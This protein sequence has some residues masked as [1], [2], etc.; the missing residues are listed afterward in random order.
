MAMP[1]SGGGIGTGEH[2]ASMATTF[3]GRLCFFNHTPT[4][5]FD[6]LR[7]LKAALLSVPTTVSSL[8]DL[9]A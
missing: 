3:V 2:R 4:R 8:T 7:L 6:S 5:S 9:E 1:S